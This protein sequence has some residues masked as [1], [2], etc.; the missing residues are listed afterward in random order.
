[1][2]HARFLKRNSFE[3]QFWGYE[4]GNVIAS[5]TGA[6][7]VGAFFSDL[8]SAWQN[9][10]MSAWR[11]AIWLAQHFPETFSTIG[12]IMVVVLAHP[13]TKLA[14]RWGGQAVSDV[15]NICV[16]GLAVVLLAYAVSHSAS[17][18]TVAACSF[19]A[20]S[21][22]LRSAGV[23]PLF[24]KMGGLLMSLGGVTLGAAGLDVLT[25]GTFGDGAVAFALGCTTAL[26]GAYV[27]GAGLL[28]YWGGIRACDEAP[29]VEC[30]RSV[31]RLV[32]PGGPIGRFFK[33]RV[34]PLIT[35]IIHN[36]VLPSLF[37]VE[38]SIRENYPFWTSMLARL[39]WRFTAGTLALATGTEA[40]VWF[41][42]ANALWAIGDIAIGVLDS[43][44]EPSAA[45]PSEVVFSGSLA[46][47]I[48]NDPREG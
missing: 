7:G 2:R 25:S 27:T 36:C 16:V 32:L 30:Q 13:V 38:S 34:D 43:E 26:T 8:H 6:G 5:M 3:V 1:M 42:V 47:A 12:V 44:P 21:S 10:G 35:R 19:V 28:T 20:G 46:P 31:V 17:F 48:S 11:A 39:P 15:V 41:A 37:W 22:L 18:L 14:G 4:I 23:F 33:R 29:E 45:N 24:L 40:G 9:S